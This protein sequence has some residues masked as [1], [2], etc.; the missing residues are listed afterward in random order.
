M[1]EASTQRAA[2]AGDLPTAPR[3]PRSRQ[4]VRQN[5]LQRGICR[6][7]MGETTIPNLSEVLASGPLAEGI[8]SQTAARNAAAAQNEQAASNTVR[9]RT[10]FKEGL[11]QMEGGVLPSSRGYNV[12]PIAAR[13]AAN[14][15]RQAV[16]LVPGSVVYRHFYAIALRYSEGFEVAIPELRRV[17]E[18]DPTHYE[19]RQQVAYGPRWH[20]AFA[21]PAWVSPPP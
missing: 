14:L 13:A 10:L 2:H 1:S 18:Q 20:D 4:P 11:A 15:F 21:Y 5:G 8:V 12:E 6:A 9:A 16:E 17:L 3:V 19:A 7:D